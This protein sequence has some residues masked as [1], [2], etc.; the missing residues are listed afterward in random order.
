MRKKIATTILAL[1][2]LI[3]NLAG[4]GKAGKN[5]IEESLNDLQQTATG[6]DGDEVVTDVG[7]PE[8]L[9]YSFTA[10]S[11]SSVNVEA[12]VIS[13]GFQ[14]A[15]IYEVEV[16]E[17]DEDLIK[18]YADRLFDESE[19]EVIKPYFMYSIQELEDEKKLLYEYI[20]INDAVNIPDILSKKLME[21]DTY[22]RKYD[23]NNVAEL[24]EGQLIYKQ[25]AVHTKAYS[26]SSEKENVTYSSARLRGMVDGE[27]WE[28][29]YEAIDGSEAQQSIEIYSYESTVTPY[30]SIASMSGE[31][32]DMYGE[33]LTNINDSQIAAEDMIKRLGYEDMEVIYTG[34]LV[35]EDYNESW[36]DGYKFSFAKSMGTMQIGFKYDSVEMLGGVGDDGYQFGVQQE[37]IHVYVSD[38]S[39]YSVTI[40]NII[41]IGDMQSDGGQDILMSFDNIDSIARELMKEDIEVWDNF[42]TFDID[43]VCLKYLVLP[44]EEGRYA[45][46]PVWIYYLGYEDK[47]LGLRYAGI[48]IN[49]VDG[50]E[51]HSSSTAKLQTGK[52]I[53]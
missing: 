41:D 45:L 24:E 31:S 47:T 39:V 40:D 23:E 48:C 42:G 13:T 4:C 32:E 7:I 5:E 53:E 16:I 18:E 6:T 52:I 29:L 37:Y 3:V 33:N 14:N 36:T 25:D 46:M 20:N 1:V 12:D 22:I 28:L 11:G 26:F 9:S 30:I 21:I 49:A 44:Y 34:Q 35:F 10:E 27:Q 38:N 8:H 43:S 15:S 2:V 51:I 19:Y 50:S 17:I